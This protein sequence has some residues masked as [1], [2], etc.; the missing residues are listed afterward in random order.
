MH[1]GGY[2][3]FKLLTPRQSAGLKFQVLG[4]FQDLGFRCQA[5]GFRFVDHAICSQFPKDP[6]TESPEP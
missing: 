5:A 6:D 1:S 4:L 2:N 3:I